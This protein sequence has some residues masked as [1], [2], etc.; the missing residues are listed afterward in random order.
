M[1]LTKEKLHPMMKLQDFFK[2]VKS[3]FADEMPISGTFV[4]D[5]DMDY[6]KNLALLIVY[7]Y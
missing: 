7:R 5:T 1:V 6:Y 3:L 2:T 4:A